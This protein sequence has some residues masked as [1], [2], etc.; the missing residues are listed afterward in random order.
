MAGQHILPGTNHASNSLT[1]SPRSGYP[2]HPDDRH[3]RRWKPQSMELKYEAI[4]HGPNPHADEPVIVARLHLASGTAG[5]EAGCSR[6]I[7][8]Y[9]EWFSGNDIPFKSTA[10]QCVGQTAAVWALAALNEVRGCL[11]SAGVVQTKEEDGSR[12]LEAEIYLAYHHEA[13]SRQALELAL[14]AIAAAASDPAFPRKD[15]Q[16]VLQKLW[17]ACHWHHPD[18]QARIL[19]QG[20]RSRDIP[21]LPL[22]DGGKL[23]QYGWGRR[24]RVFFET[25]SN[26]DGFL[27]G[28]L[29]KSKVETKAMLAALG[30]P[31]PRYVLVTA[32]ADLD[33][34]AQTI[35]WPCVIKPMDM[36]TGKGVTAGIAETVALQA[37]F[38]NAR[39]YTREPL[40]VEAHCP[41]VD[42][43]LFMLDGKL[44]AAVRREPSSVTGD[45]MRTVRQLID[46]LNAARSSNML[47]SR[48]LVP[49][50]FDGLLSD[51]LAANTANLDTVLPP[52][53]RMT[54]R[55]N[56]NRSTGGVAHD[57]IELVHPQVRAMAERLA[58]VTGLYAAGFDYITTD[59]GKSPAESGGQMIEINT[60]PGLA[61]MVAAG[62]DP[63][64]LASRVLG[65]LP[66]RIPVTL[67][68]VA[69]G[70]VASLRTKLLSRPALPDGAWVSGQEAFVGSMPLQV[71]GQRPWTAVRTALRYRCVERLLVVSTADEIVRHGLPVDKIQR[72]VLDDVDLPEPWHAVLKRC[73][74]DIRAGHVDQKPGFEL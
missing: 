60:V 73:S 69:P 49:V 58:E 36:G 40:M 52:G 38:R 48:Y 16:P 27:G 9:P 3:N 39:R 19:M 32:E 72:T 2:D 44:A 33:K 61:V 14:K 5:L 11:R 64:T 59:I 37:A 42:Y 56:A 23:W 31:T 1:N 70:A 51:H 7:D 74:I 57:V 50:E 54:L 20:A 53:R 68:L 34:A 25:G 71:R 6:L 65:D 30:I 67:W 22:V 41:G 29:A 63:V 8:L 13:T 62:L 35:G 15:L 47:R 55:S 17:Q 4:Y 28:R 24:A 45:G 66:A 26:A 10:A 21:V 46:E 18:W 43:R 12:K